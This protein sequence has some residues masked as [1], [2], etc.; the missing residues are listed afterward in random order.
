MQPNA[1]LPEFTLHINP[2]RDSAH[3]V[4]AVVLVQ[5]LE[6]AQRAFELIGLFVEGKSVKTRARVPAALSR[7]YQLVCKLPEPGSYAVPI[8]VGDGAADLVSAESVQH[9][10]EKFRQLLRSVSAQEGN[11]PAEIIPDAGV[12]RRVLEAVRGMAPRAGSGWTLGVRLQ[13]DPE[14]AVLDEDTPAFVQQITR[15]DE[16]VTD[17]RTVTGELQSINFA[18]RKI[19]IVYPVLNRDL[20]CF[21]EDQVEDMLLENRRQLIQVTGRVVVDETGAPKRIIEVSSIQDLDMSAFEIDIVRQGGLVLRAKHKIEIEPT[22]D[23]TRQ[24]LCLLAEELGIDVFAETREQLR[25]ELFEQLHV[26]WTEYAQADEALLTDGAKG[27]RARL[28]SAFEAE[29]AA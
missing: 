22:L 15:V 28:L 11:R 24:L 10:F 13:G 8:T 2:P 1:A 9:A 14:P 26:L 21:Y 6:N 3:E 27:L 25:S 18:E 5:V 4:P 23:E 7:R 19:T 17:R 29:H 16:D 12:R 20:E